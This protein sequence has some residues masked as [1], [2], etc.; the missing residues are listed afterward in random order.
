MS[1]LNSEDEEYVMNLLSSLTTYCCK[2][3]RYKDWY[4]VQFPYLAGDEDLDGAFEEVSKVFND[5]GIHVKRL[6]DVY[7][8]PILFKLTPKELES[9]VLLNKIKGA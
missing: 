2:L 9:F 1:I 3:T 6:T 7:H 8:T 4:F 5:C